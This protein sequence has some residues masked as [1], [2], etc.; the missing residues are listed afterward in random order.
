MQ[1]ALIELGYDIPVSNGKYGPATTRAVS[2][3]YFEN[4]DID[5]GTSVGPLGWTEIFIALDEQRAVNKSEK[6]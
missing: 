4:G 3:F 2:K 5:D 6:E 1:A